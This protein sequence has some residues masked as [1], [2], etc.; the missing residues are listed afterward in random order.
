MAWTSRKDMILQRGSRREN[1]RQELAITTAGHNNVWGT[2]IV[3]RL[4][5]VWAG[6][7][8]AEGFSNQ[9]ACQNRRTD[10]GRAWSLRYSYSDRL[11]K[12]GKIQGVWVGGIGM[13][14]RRCHH[15]G[16]MWG[17]KSKTLRKRPNGWKLLILGKKTVEENIRHE[18][19]LGSQ[20]CDISG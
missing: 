12:K 17:G 7:K 3:K 6:S 1:S 20:N 19:L 14:S 10:C 5:A 18:F 15:P 11:G 13:V 2:H 16:S 8:V 4:L 9:A